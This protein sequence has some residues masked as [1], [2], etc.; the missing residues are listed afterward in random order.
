MSE[1]NYRALGW[2]YGSLS[3]QRFGAMIGPVTFV[4][5]NGR[6]VS[7]L[8]L[9]P[10]VGQD[11]TDIEPGVIAHLRGE[12]PCV[13]FGVS[14]T[15]GG[16]TP[17]WADVIQSA[18]DSHML[19]GHGSNTEWKFTQVT[20]S[21]LELTCIY[22]EDNDVISLTRRIRAIPNAAAVEFSLFVSVRRPTRLPIGLHF[23]FGAPDPLTINPGL[24]ARGW[25]YPGSIGAA[26]AFEHDRP[27][28]NLA[29]VPGKAGS[30]LDASRFP[31]STPNEDL[32]QLNGIEGTCELEFPVESY[33]LTLSWN[34]EHFPS[35]LLWLSNRAYGG[36]PLSGRTVALGVE[37]ICSAFGMGRAV[38]AASNPAAQ[39]GVKTAIAIDPDRPFETRYRMSAAEI[40]K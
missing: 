40:N 2:R 15:A 25:T 16:F 33:R 5:P 17:R 10:W 18:P 8:F 37:P 19:H 9:P 6:A 7:P 38:S 34:S 36:A 14:P 13:P 27:F 39:S 31:F 24:F 11:L 22:P 26:Q 23:T 3:V 21:M 1:A 20:A 35:L 4:L 30:E 12:W 28:S 29:R 32:L